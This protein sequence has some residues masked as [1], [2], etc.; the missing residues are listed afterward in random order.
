MKGKILK[1]MVKLMG[2]D[3]SQAKIISQIVEKELRKNKE[4]NLMKSAFATKFDIKEDIRV[5]PVVCE[6]TFNTDSWVVVVDNTVVTQEEGYDDIYNYFMEGALTKDEKT[7]E[8][9]MKELKLAK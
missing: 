5:A 7:V 6:D 2:E 1:K 3:K 4:M 9:Y 8:K